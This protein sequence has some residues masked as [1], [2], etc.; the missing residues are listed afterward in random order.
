[1]ATI[2]FNIPDAVLQRVLDDIAIAKD[3]ATFGGGL[4]KAQFA[5]KVIIDF[6]MNLCRRVEG[7]AA[8]QGA[9]QTV[10]TDIVIT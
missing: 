3:F 6:V 1:M 5:K 7:R 8:E 10:N 9:Q 2:S 4:T